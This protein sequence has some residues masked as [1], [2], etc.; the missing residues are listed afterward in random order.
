[1]IE[2]LW[3]IPE[4]ETEECQGSTREKARKIGLKKMKKIVNWVEMIFALQGDSK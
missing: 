4:A 1:M 2:L 3:R